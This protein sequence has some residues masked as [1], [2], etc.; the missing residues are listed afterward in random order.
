ME[1]DAE[2]GNEALSISFSYQSAFGCIKR[3]HAND[4]QD[5]QLIW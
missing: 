1:F 4:F 5:F 3:Q 2:S